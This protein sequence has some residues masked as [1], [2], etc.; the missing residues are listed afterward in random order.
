MGSSANR[1]GLAQWL[2]APEN[3]LTSRVTVNR[4]WQEVFGTGLV[5]TAE[6]FGIMGEP[7]SNQELLDWIA[8]YFRESGWDV[9]KLFR[10]IVMS[11]T[12][13]QSAEATPEKIE[14][15]PANRW[16]S[17]GPRFRLDAE[18]VRDYALS[19]SGLLAPKIGGPSVKPYQPEGVWEAVAMPESNTRNYKRD[20]GDALYRRSLYT[21]WKRAAPPALMELFNAPSREV[22]C[23]RRERTNTPLQALATL[24]DPQFVE[25]AGQLANRAF[26]DADGNP[27]N[28]ID[29]IARNVLSRVLRPEERIVVVEGYEQMLAHYTAQPDEAAKL[30]A[31]G[32]SKLTPGNNTAQ[33]AA[34]AMV[35]N[36]LLNLDE[37]LNK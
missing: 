7:P 15:D 34:L 28:A 16:L 23:A 10:E 2:I 6:D 20:S 31:I 33:V 36:Q 35:A 12:Y 32:E 27:R 9:K 4:F 13:R 11:A 29:Q 1:L 3:P 19:V 8:I 37:V 17:R 14:K 22:S 25:A 30:L 21:F 24:N 26:K 18:V 5:K